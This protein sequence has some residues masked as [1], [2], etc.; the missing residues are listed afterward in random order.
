MLHSVSLFVLL[1]KAVVRMETNFAE[2][3]SQHVHQ[4]TR[5]LYPC[6]LFF[7]PLMLSSGFAPIQPSVLIKGRAALPRSQR[8]C[9]I[10]H[11]LSRIKKKGTYKLEHVWYDYLWGTTSQ[12]Q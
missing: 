7:P 1:N 6:C 4:W 10:F 11:P 3:C 8:A 2:L 5:S 12:T 9:L